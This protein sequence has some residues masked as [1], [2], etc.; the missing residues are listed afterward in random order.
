MTQTH[1]LF[2]IRRS[3]YGS[4]RVAGCLDMLLT[5][6]TF[7]QRVTVVFSGESVPLLAAERDS[8]H[9]G[10]KDPFKALSA[11]PLYGVEKVYVEKEAMLS[12]GLETTEAPPAMVPL[13][14]SDLRQLMN[15]ADRVFIC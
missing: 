4:G 7:D 12:A 1:F 5:A 8:R 14:R 13:D 11:L 9:I 2:L 15:D 10:L 3:P 6:A